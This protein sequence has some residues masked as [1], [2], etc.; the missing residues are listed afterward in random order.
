MTTF[1]PFKDSLHESLDNHVWI[2]YKQDSEGKWILII[3]WEEYPEWSMKFNMNVI[4]SEI[5]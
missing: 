1:E 5:K 3:D 4:I 2:N